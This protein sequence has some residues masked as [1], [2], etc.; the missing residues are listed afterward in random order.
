MRLLCLDLS[1]DIVEVW[2]LIEV[3]SWSRGLRRFDDTERRDMQKRIIQNIVL[4][5]RI[6]FGFR[7]S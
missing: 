7:Y 3:A 4:F 6:R 2:S 1:V 5:D